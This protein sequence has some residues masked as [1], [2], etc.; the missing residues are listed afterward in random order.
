MI[1][2]KYILVNGKNLIFQK[3]KAKSLREQLSESKLL[4]LLAVI[5]IYIHIGAAK[6]AKSLA[7]NTARR[8]Q[9]RDLSAL[10][11]DDRDTHKLLL[12]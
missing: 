12:S 9:I 1:Y 4:D 8:A 10:A 5:Q 3:I 2:Q 7:A 6:F 11:A